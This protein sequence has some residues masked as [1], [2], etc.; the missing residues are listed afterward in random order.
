MLVLPVFIFASGLQ[1]D[2]HVYLSTLKK[3]TLP[4]ATMF[5]S[6][7]CPHY[8][9]ECIIYLA[10]AILAAPKG[11][12]INRTIFAGDIFVVALLGI[13][14]GTNEKWYREKFGEDSVKGEIT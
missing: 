11:H 1:Y 13:S 2:C 12:I 10:L 9:A 7:I 8:F 14:A 4:N 6:I 3:Y 5:R